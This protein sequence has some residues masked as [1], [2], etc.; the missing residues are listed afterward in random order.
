MKIVF[1]C[2][3]APQG[4]DLYKRPYGR[5]FHIP[6]LLAKEGFEVTL[7]LVDYAEN[8]TLITSLE[9]IQ[10]HIVSLNKLNPLSTLKKIEAAVTH[11]NPDWI[12]GLSD[13][14]YGII[15]HRIGKKYGY[16]IFVDAYDNY[17]SYIPWLLPI[18][19]LWR[20]AC[21]NA[22]L[23]T[24]AGPQLLSLM[25][26][27]RDKNKVCS[28]IPMAAD[29][30]FKPIEKSI[31]R[32]QLKLPEAFL[33]GY[34]GS[35]H[36]SRDPDQLFSIVSS[37]IKIDPSIK[38]VISGKKHS[39]VTI[40]NN[41]KSNILELGYIEDNEIPIACNAMDLLLAL[42]QPSKFGNYAYPVKI[43]EAM[44]CGKTILATRTTSTE[45]ILKE[46]P[47]N[48]IEWRDVEQ[49]VEKIINRKLTL[50]ISN[51]DIKTWE[52]GIKNLSSYLLNSAY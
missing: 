24:A 3:R 37:T 18:H 35:L 5:F 17:E 15:A 30:I 8:E 10:L 1:I 47:E 38:F 49:V 11:I 36:P 13:T 6:N 9:N 27:N 2:K 43:Y 26:I 46:T 44:A 45:W 19:W 40:P 12:S 34:L 20:N 14:W 33:V 50:N 51:Y 28:V 21:C 39:S 32:K 4:R 41:L 42:G 31:A 48:L 52:D 25:S 23:L 29:P 7:I 16:K 22:D